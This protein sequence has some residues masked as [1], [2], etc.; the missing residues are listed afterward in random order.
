M[1]RASALIFL[2]TISETKADHY[3][4]TSFALFEHFSLCHPDSNGPPRLL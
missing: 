1:M 3:R 4:L 2:H